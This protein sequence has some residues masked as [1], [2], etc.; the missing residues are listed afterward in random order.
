MK[1]IPDTVTNLEDAADVE[2][3]G[4]TMYDKF[5]KEAKEEGFDIIAY[6]FEW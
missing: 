4:W 1:K 3:Y 2:H 6:V 5:A